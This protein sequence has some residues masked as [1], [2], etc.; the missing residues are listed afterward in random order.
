MTTSEFSKETLQQLVQIVTD[1]YDGHLTILRFTGGWKVTLGTP[2][3]TRESYEEVAKLPQFQSLENA[4][5]WAT[6]KDCQD[7]HRTLKELREVQWR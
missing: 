4:L 7:F 1:S 6:S 3:M 5:A 2:Q